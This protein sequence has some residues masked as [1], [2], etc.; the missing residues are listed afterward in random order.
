MSP[1]PDSSHPPRLGGR[2][3]FITGAAS[4]IGLACAQLF[5][6]HGALV[7][8]A[9]RDPKVTD[10]AAEIGAVG[11][12]VD[13]RD[14]TA[15]SAAVAKAAEAMG[16]LDGVVN[17][18]GVA[19][20]KPLGQMELEDWSTVMAINLNAPYL[21]CRAALPWLTAAGGTVVNI[22]SGAGLLPGGGGSTAYSGSKGGLIAFTKALAAELAPAVR[23]NVVCPGLTKTPMTAF[24]FEGYEGRMEEAPAVARY[25]LRRPALPE[26]IANAC[27]FLTSGESSYMTG[28]TVAVDGGRT[29]H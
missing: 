7:A 9:D 21:V 3:V 24:M 5:V 14:A 28:S 27:L 4:G 1:T 13:L 23:A 25:A 10:L 16:G 26:E 11:L 15:V 12:V 6:R 20:L 17:A 29:F 18:A 8:M 22:A 19:T 2:K